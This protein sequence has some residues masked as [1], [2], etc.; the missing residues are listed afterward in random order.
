MQHG[1][2]NRPFLI[3]ESNSFLALLIRVY[4]AELLSWRGRLSVRCPSVN[5]GFSETTAWIQVNFMGY[6]HVSTIPSDPRH[7]FFQ[8]F[9]FS[10]CLHFFFFFVSTG[11]LGEWKFQ[12]TTPLTV[13]IQFQPNFMISMLV[14]MEAITFL[15][16]C[17]ILWHFLKF[18]L[19]QDHM[20]LEMSKRYWPPTV[21][22]WFQI[23]VM[24]IW[25]TMAEYRLLLFLAIDQV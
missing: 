17:Q 10:K 20:G 19:T 18:F 4:T 9:Q 1:H 12:N 5:W 13:F 2:R 8:N 6:S 23:N 25:L 7:F 14:M 16:I 11:S 22:I 15:P 24:R 3:W 21:F